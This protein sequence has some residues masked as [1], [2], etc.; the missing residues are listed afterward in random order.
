MFA[1]P[2]AWG[3]PCGPGARSVRSLSTRVRVPRRSARPDG[4]SPRDGRAT[5]TPP[6]PRCGPSSRCRSRS[7]AVPAR[8]R[9]IRL[10]PRPLRA[11]TTVQSRTP[12]PR[13]R[14]RGCPTAP[15]SP[16]GGSATRPAR[17]SRCMHSGP[18]TQR[19]CPGCATPR[20]LPARRLGRV[21]ISMS[22]TRPPGKAQLRSIGSG[23]AYLARRLRES[24][25]AMIGFGVWRRHPGARAPVLRPALPSHATGWPRAPATL[26]CPS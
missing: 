13:R 15:Q 26:R 20:S 25:S 10:S 4:P 19:R 8:R 23:V 11:P 18:S 2:Q 6:A 12:R 17:V 9:A 22:Q 24:A 1:P 14:C 21:R 16:V 3:A 7:G 5:Q